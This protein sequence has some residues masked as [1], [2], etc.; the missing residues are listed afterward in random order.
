MYKISQFKT[1]SQFMKESYFFLNGVIFKR[2]TETLTEKQ[3]IFK[4]NNQ[5]ISIQS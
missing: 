2:A 1:K 3:A 4:T 5:M